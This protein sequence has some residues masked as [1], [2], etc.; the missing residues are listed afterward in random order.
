MLC[1]VIGCN[2]RPY[3]TYIDWMLHPEELMQ[4]Y[5]GCILELHKISAQCVSI[6]RA[7]E[8]FA[9][10]VAERAND[11]EQFGKKILAAQMVVAASYLEYQNNLSDYHKLQAQNKISVNKQQLSAELLE[12][13]K[14]LTKYHVH[15]SNVQILSTVIAKTTKF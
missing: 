2:S 15:T 9:T 1:C 13:T 12:L 8:Y 4:A 6:M 11:P 3:H 5:Q 14:S 10:L 7:Q